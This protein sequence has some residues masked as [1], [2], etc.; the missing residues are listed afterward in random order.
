MATARKL[1]SFKVETVE[2]NEV[3]P[4]EFEI[5]DEKFEAYGDVPGAVLL[6]FIAST[7]AG[8]P[9]GDSAKAVWDYLRDSMDA[10]NWSR[11]RAK[12]K[13]RNIK[14][15]DDFYVDLVVSLIQE[16]S[17]RPTEES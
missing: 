3:E 7:G 5:G 14:L 4:I 13:D 15:P 1:K 2:T 16:R 17:S 9:S 6:D 8:V 11:F 10:D 12:I